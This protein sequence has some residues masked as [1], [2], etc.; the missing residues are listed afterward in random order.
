MTPYLYSHSPNTT[1]PWAQSPTGTASFPAGAPGFDLIVGI[2][3]LLHLPL[4]VHGNKEGAE[5]VQAVEK[6]PE[7][8][9]TAGFVPF[10]VHFT[11]HAI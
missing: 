9:K 7:E 2:W 3:D 10:L 6:A 8:N 1:S 5:L 4:F 11:M